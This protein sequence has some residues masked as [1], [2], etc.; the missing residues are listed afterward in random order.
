[1]RLGVPVWGD[2]D[3]PGRD[4]STLLGCIERS[5]VPGASVFARSGCRS[6]RPARPLGRPCRVRQPSP[7]LRCAAC[8][9]NDRRAP[10]P[11]PRTPFRSP[12][13]GLYPRRPDRAACR[14]GRTEIP[15]PRVAANTTHLRRALL[16]TRF[17]AWPSSRANQTG[18][19]TAVPSFGNVTRSAYSWFSRPEKPRPVPGCAA[20]SNGVLCRRRSWTR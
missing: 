15:R 4:L 14:A 9:P 5:S 1:V 11:P 17:E 18:V 13:P 20:V 19:G 2:Q 16:G 6:P 12:R 8:G 3:G 10:P 7:F